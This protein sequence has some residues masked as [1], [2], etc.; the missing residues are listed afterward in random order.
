M[1]SS[2]DVGGDDDASSNEETDQVGFASIS[3]G[4]DGGGLVESIR[5]EGCRSESLK[6]VKVAVGAALS[7]WGV[8]D[9]RI[10]KLQHLEQ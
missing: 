1:I 2:S 4:L 3:L 7:S 9:T 10:A 5:L 8:R 6:L